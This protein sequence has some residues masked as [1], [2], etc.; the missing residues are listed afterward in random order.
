[1]RVLIVGAG[2]AGL[3]VATALARSSS[4]ECDLVE[5]DRDWTTI[6]A[7]IT[8]HP[9]GMRA[10]RTLGLADAV[11]AAGQPIELVRT[12]TAGGELRSEFPGE[13]WDGV[14]RTVAIHRAALQEVLRSGARET[15]VRLGTTV[16]GLT[17][18][19]DA[20]EASFSDGTRRRY[21]LAV[22]ADGIRSSLRSMCFVDTPPQ[23]VGQMYWRTSV[24]A[25]VVATATMMFD[26]RRF[27]AL[28]PLGGGQTY[29]AAQLF[30]TDPFELAPPDVVPA[31]RE[32]FADFASPMSDALACF[33]DATVHFGP[34]EEIERDQW[35]AG[36][37]LL[38]GDA[39]HACSPT[40]AQGASMAFEDAVVLARLLEREAGG[41]PPLDR[42]LDAFVARR[43][44][45]ARWVRE[46]TR[47]HME[48]LNDGSAELTELLRETNHHLARP[49]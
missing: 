18:F 17:Q 7:G 8:L 28:I 20:V 25:D 45:R 23:Y 32:R 22:G 12:L 3:S 38:V 47:L 21:D 31:V 6:G 36:R 30:G 2:I 13:V 26:E 11:E 24:N 42:V 40:L 44:P 19:A 37:V 4:I 1:V 5:R 33:D 10:L 15:P 35:R 39:A 43:E 29:I 46:R 14:G 41:D 34:A 16:T 49:I 9:N 48:V 27:V